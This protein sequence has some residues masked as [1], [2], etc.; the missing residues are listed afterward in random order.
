MLQAT[1]VQGADTSIHDK[2]S[3]RSELSSGTVS[4]TWLLLTLFPL[5]EERGISPSQAKQLIPKRQL[6]Q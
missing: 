3:I 1:V 5:L 6:L 2:V 4:H